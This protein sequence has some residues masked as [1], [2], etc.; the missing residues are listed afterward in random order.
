MSDGD[1]REV[2]GEDIE[3]IEA[4]FVT[5]KQS[6]VRS[7]EGGHVEI[8]QA[9]VLSIDGERIEIAQSAAALIHGNEVDLTQSMSAITT[10]RNTNLNYSFSP[11]SLSKDKTDLSRCAVG[12]VGAR[13]VKSEKTSSLL[14]IAGRVEGEVT[15]VFD[16]RSALAL[17]A[18]VGGVLGLVSLFSKR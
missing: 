3:F 17:G 13:T 15:A 11:F 2:E 9:G 5:V 6:T 8:Q 14:M 7:I 10:A 18:A 4:E 1:V 16:W 12:I